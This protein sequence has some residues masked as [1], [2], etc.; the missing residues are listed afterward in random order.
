MTAQVNRYYALVVTAAPHREPHIRSI[1]AAHLRHWGLADHAEPV[2]RGVGE[3]FRNA[4]Q[5][6]GPAPGCIVELRWNGRR[7]T[8]AVSDPDAAPPRPR[9]DGS[10]GLAR[11]AALGDTWGTA[12]TPTGKIVWFTR[13]A[14]APVPA[15]AP[16]AAAAVPTDVPSR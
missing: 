1:V 16:P 6:A 3:L 14:P 12:P 7:L 5:H 13:A 9:D 4:A 2:C 8:A 15:C 11:V 10:G